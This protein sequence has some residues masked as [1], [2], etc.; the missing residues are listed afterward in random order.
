MDPAI[1]LIIIFIVAPLIER[2]LKAGK[3]EQQPPE[4]RP[5]RRMP[6]QPFPQR[7][8]PQRR[9]EP[10]AGPAPEDDAA[11]AM[12]PD[13][14][15]EILTGEKRAPQLPVPHEEPE[16]FEEAYVA[17]E[18]G[19]EASSLEELASLEGPSPGEWVSRTPEESTVIVPADAYVRPLPKRE[20]P[21]VVSLE[22]LDIDDRKRH[23]EFHERLDSLGGPARVKRPAP[24][25]YRFTSDED[26]RR[27]V[28]MSEILGTPKGLE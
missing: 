17:D 13:D 14:L 18:Y 27:A 9:Q 21:R 26:L 16:E 7:Q 15:W 23:E 19:D 5:Q 10:V 11:A 2:L 24:N 12:L 28:V 3:G 25:A 20:V 1:L 6:P 4:Q 8:P 22:E